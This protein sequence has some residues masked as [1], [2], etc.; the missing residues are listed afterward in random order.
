VVL[1]GAELEEPVRLLL[2]V[3]LQILEEVVVALELPVLETQA[4]VV[5]A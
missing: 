3:E 1:V 5:Q 4:T 2:L